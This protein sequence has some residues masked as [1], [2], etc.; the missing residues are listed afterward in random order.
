MR[1]GDYF[2][3][4]VIVFKNDAMILYDDILSLVLCSLGVLG[5]KLRW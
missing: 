2:K 3:I 4:K 1:I 5:G